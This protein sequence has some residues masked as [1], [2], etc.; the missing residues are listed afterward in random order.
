MNDDNDRDKN[1]PIAYDLP[2]DKP[3]SDI[4]SARDKPIRQLRNDQ[5]KLR[6]RARREILPD[7]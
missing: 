4:D 1:E 3:K 6:R 5:R 7:R 2:D